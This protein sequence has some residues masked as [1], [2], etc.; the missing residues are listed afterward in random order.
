MWLQL[1]P[2]TGSRGFPHRNW[3]HRLMWPEVI[4]SYFPQ[5]SS[6]TF[7]CEE[8]ELALELLPALRLWPL[9]PLLLRLLPVRYPRTGKPL[10]PLVLSPVMMQT[11]WHFRLGLGYR[12]WAPEVRAILPV[13]TSVFRPTPADRAASNRLWR[14]SSSDWSSSLTA[15]VLLLPVRLSLPAGPA[16][17][18]L[19][20]LLA[21][22]YPLPSN[23]HIPSHIS[24]ST[25]N[26]TLNLP[27]WKLILKDR[28]TW[29]VDGD[30]H[31]SPSPGL[32]GDRGSRV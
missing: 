17:P 30:R 18:V 21:H 10:L 24:W 11:R 13:P 3:Q 32:L 25:V 19:S 5:S 29:S 15:P 23:L 14:V 22:G 28:L 27:I 31:S 7:S 2:L 4:S 9:L 16:L 12:D 6:W 1:E 20:H 26:Q 8:V